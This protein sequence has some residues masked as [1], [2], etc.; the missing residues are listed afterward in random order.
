MK[1]FFIQIKIYLSSLAIIQKL[2]RVVSP[3]FLGMLAASFVLWYIAKLSYTYTTELDV[4]VVIEEQYIDARCV[5][6]GVGTNLFGYKIKG[7]AK[8]RI[9]LSELRYEINEADS[10]IS[11]INSSLSGALS[12]RLS[13]IKIISIDADPRIKLTNSHK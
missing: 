3:I 10:T 6:E 11:I 2:G 12:V 9:P 13:D 5:V 4:R 1:N 8:L 7:G